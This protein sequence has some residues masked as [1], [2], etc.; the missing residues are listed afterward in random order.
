MVLEIEQFR[1]DKGGNPDIIRDSQKR[2]H[3]DV[4][5]VDVVIEADMEWRKAQFRADNLKK[6]MNVCNKAIGMKMKTKEAHGDSADVMKEITD[7]LE[8]LTLDNVNVM[9]I[10]QIKAVK[11]QIEAALKDCDDI[12]LAQ[13]AIR[14]DA[15]RRIGNLVA[16]DVPVSDNE[17]NNRVEVQWGEIV[18][19]K[20][21]HRDLIEMIDGVDM[22]R[23][24]VTGG[25]RCYY[26]KGPAVL[27]EFA[28][29]QLGMVQLLE[30]DY[31]PMTTPFFMR[32]E[33]MAEVAQ[34]SQFDEELYKVTGKASEI[35][36][37]TEIEE[38]YLIATS[39]QPLCA[40]HREE[41]MNVKSLPQRYAGWSTCFRQEVGSH[42]RDTG[43]I[44]RVHQFEKLEQFVLCSPRDGESW[45]EHGKMIKNA[46]IFYQTL[47]IPYR[48][49]NIVS[50]ALNDAAAKK[51]DLE[52]WFPGS[53]A[54]RELVSC[55]N[56][57]DY[58]SRRLRI[59]YGA[60]KDK[61]AKTQEYVHMLNGTM[62]ATTR[63]IC[64]ILENYQTED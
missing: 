7:K 48:V 5:L 14:T 47:G 52:G 13:D 49:V 22:K 54:F 46:E 64:A 50:G 20:L 26:L 56:C 35:E 44:F 2:R 12:R 33:I 18:E 27:L 4:G 63:V 16:D 39:E 9:T 41:W 60:T 23:G 1:A 57:T 53:K 15:L 30:K 25:N 21:S 51:L 10:T 31:T 58:Q 45:V 38:K 32:K 3:K 19:K 40:Y 61:N 55:S 34:L 6:V 43:G 24:S 29:V 28:I 17:D 36:G 37:S 42:G 62:A 11:E 8:V 59:R